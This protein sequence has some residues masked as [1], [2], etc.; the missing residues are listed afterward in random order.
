M[1]TYR[2]HKDIAGV[3]TFKPMEP[4]PAEHFHIH[5]VNNYNYGE[6]NYKRNA[7]IY[8]NRMRA[9]KVRRVEFLDYTADSMVRKCYLGEGCVVKKGIL[10]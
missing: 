2:T 8:T 9:N 1:N 10:V 6:G 7:M 5:Y 4:R 3:V